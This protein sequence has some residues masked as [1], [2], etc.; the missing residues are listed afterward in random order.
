MR[1]NKL[2]DGDLRLAG[3]LSAHLG[4]DG[5]S[6]EPLAALSTKDWEAMITK[7]PPTDGGGSAT[8]RNARALGFQA[9]VERLHP[10]PALL[11]R[12]ATGSLNF[13]DAD[14]QDMPSLVAKH[15]AVAD[16]LLKN[17][18]LDSGAAEVLPDKVAKVLQ[19]LGR[20]SRSGLVME[21]GADLISA[22]IPG[23]GFAITHGR[24]VILQI[25]RD[26][27]STEHIEQ[28]WHYTEQLYR[29]GKNF[30][31]E[32]S[33]S[34]R[35]PWIL[36][37][38]KGE[39]QPE[40]RENLPTLRGLFGDLDEC[41]CRPCESVLGLPAY[42]VDLLN[43]L[44]TVPLR[45]GSQVPYEGTPATA[46][47]VLRARRPD[48]FTLPLSCENA[49]GEIQHIELA[50]EILQGA[51][52]ADPD[53]QLRGIPYP[54]RLPFDAGFAELN[55]LAP[56]LGL[57][58]SALLPLTAAPL[59]P[60]LAAA[61]LGIAQDQQSETLSEWTL[62]TTPRSGA[63]LWAAW[64]LPNSA[65]VTITDPSSGALLTGVPGV[66]LGRASVL[67]DRMGVELDALD[68]ILATRYMGGLT[69]SNRQQCKASEMILSSTA[70]TVFDRLHR[71]T[72]LARKLAGW[73][74]PLLDSALM[75][76]N[77]PAAGRQATHYEAALQTIAAA[78][79]ARVAL[80]LRPEEVLGLRMPL[81]DVWLDAG[82][83][84]SLFQGCFGALRAELA[85]GG[86]ILDALGK[87][88]AAL[89]ADSRALAALIAP[90]GTAAAA[91]QVGS[92][93][94]AANLTW[95]FRHVTLA[96]ALEVSVP[97]LVRLKLLT[98]IDPFDPVSATLTPQAGFERLLAI[99]SA[100]AKIAASGVSIE[101][102]ADVLLPGAVVAQLADRSAGM[103]LSAAEPARVTTLLQDLQK[104]LRAI[105]VDTEAVVKQPGIENLLRPWYGQEAAARILDAVSLAATV[106]VAGTAQPATD[107]AVVQALSEPSR[108]PRQLG[109]PLPLFTVA[110]ATALLTPN[111]TAVSD[112]AARF[113]DIT[114][115]VAERKREGHLV[116]AIQAATGL[117]E[118]K[119]VAIL[120]GGLKVAAATTA[121]A[122]LLADTFWRPDPA[123]AVNETARA[124]LHAWVTRLY[125]YA[126]V[127]RNF[128]ESAPWLR[129]A[130]QIRPAGASADGI[131][132]RDLLAPRE[133]ASG[134]WTPRWSAWSAL[135]DLR[136][137]L[138]TERLG[139][140][141]AAG[142]FKNM[143]SVN[144]PVAAAELEPLATRLAVAPAEV[145][146]MAGL[147][148]PTVTRES[149]RDPVGLTRLLALAQALRTSRATAGQAAR[150]LAVDANGDAARVA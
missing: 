1:L 32:V 37:L 114:R 40:V 26:K 17:G 39:V 31:G 113:A 87:V 54:W 94:N 24:D 20:F 4:P 69:L 92:T 22:G 50:I 75:A 14:L 96:R 28:Y 23:P 43:L 88:A 139:A 45:K 30:L 27:Y 55:L 149:L 70:E 104:E 5:H 73:T 120:E 19:N 132:W 121:A 72:R 21:A 142:H 9:Q 140:D 18:P 111:T 108:T 146:A 105:T 147:A 11:G 133:F 134:A 44:K 148:L 57:T 12:L 63:S 99:R 71:F 46:Q 53:A 115:R 95:L 150:L 36:G 79:R 128:G 7:A 41:A 98:G 81:T 118:S 13:N 64:G 56:R 117:S 62:I 42:L 2:T 107:L 109:D 100:A 47:S 74:V 52:G 93:L 106:P 91:D 76:C 78:E 49:Q 130:D 34:N 143:A 77:L 119:V 10:L 82:A 90:V 126:A 84:S 15:G 122:A 141:V 138:G 61:T 60:R 33:I 144:G 135:L 3:A 125:K 67:M 65:T 80:D 16:A 131:D 103:D 127:L 110:E 85:A 58:R 124:D 86:S 102:T 97:Q 59:A 25:L 145:Q 116:S 136:A 66:V 129:L 8:D 89:G 6:I 38:G 51:L 137:L 48:I 123:P 112:R 35:L 83:A 29:G 68:R 101:F